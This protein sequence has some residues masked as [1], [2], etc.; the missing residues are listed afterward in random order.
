M[1]V[2]ESGAPVIDPMH[3]FVVGPLFGGGPVGSFLTITNSTL[4]MFVSILAISALL[5]MG[6]RGRALVPTRTQSVAE[7]LYTFI[8]SMVM[9]ILGEDGK[10]YFPYIFTIFIFI[11]FSNLLGMVPGSFTTTSHIAVTAILALAVFISVIAIGFMKHGAG[12]LKL[13]WVESAPL[14]LRP[15]LALIEVISFFVRPL[16][17]SIRL[18]GNMMAG[19]AVLKVFAGLLALLI[20]SGLGILAILPLGL[21]V[22]ITA[23]EF[24]V[25]CVQAYIFAIL[26]CIYLNDALHPSH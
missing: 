3:Q 15:V 13:F 1:A 22:A 17:H 21:M 4:W 16:S 20:Y 6:M 7:I 2:S 5:I 26:T 8:R 12:F 11:L 24:L 10:T 19:H 9:D 18:A 25:A 14:A 23:L